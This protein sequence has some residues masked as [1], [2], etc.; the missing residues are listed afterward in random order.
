MDTN[1][2]IFC[3]INQ[4]CITTWSQNSITEC[5]FLEYKV[6]S[7]YAEKEWYNNVM[8]GYAFG[9][10]K[11]GYHGIYDVLNFG[12]NDRCWIEYCYGL[13]VCIPNI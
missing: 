9:R 1:L 4:N 5:S 7:L 12:T 13:S 2:T 6:C 8:Q 11:T 10:I 3:L